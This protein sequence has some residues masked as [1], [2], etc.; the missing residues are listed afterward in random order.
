MFALHFSFWKNWNFFLGQKRCLSNHIFPLIIF[1]QSLQKFY[2]MPFFFKHSNSNLEMSVTWKC[3]DGI[4]REEISDVRNEFRF[5]MHKTL[6]QLQFDCQ[7]FVH[8]PWSKKNII[9]VIIT[10]QL[11]FRRLTTYLCNL[12]MFSNII[13]QYAQTYSVCFQRVE[14]VFFSMQLCFSQ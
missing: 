5:Q 4:Q 3:F 9:N 12:S 14:G 2:K 10:S 13:K 8:Y 1:F 6:F 7:M 11:F